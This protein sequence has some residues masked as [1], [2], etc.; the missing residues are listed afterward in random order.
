MEFT[1]VR[2]E[3]SQVD[4]M[5]YKLI[6]DIEVLSQL[7]NELPND[8]RGYS[9]LFT[10]NQMVNNIIAGDDQWDLALLW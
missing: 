8:V 5:A 3:V 7:A 10:A 9:A 1:V 6:K 2:A 4:S